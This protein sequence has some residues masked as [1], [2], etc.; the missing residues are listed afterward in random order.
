M[1]LR[2]NLWQREMMVGKILCGSVV[3]KINLTWAGGSSRIFN[4][5]LNAAL[6]SM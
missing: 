6:L 4:R 5:A 1:G 3:A 2:S